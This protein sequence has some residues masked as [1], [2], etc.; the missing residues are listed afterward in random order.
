MWS[1]ILHDV[2]LSTEGGLTFIAT[3]VLHVPVSALSLGAFVRKNDLQD[4][5][6]HNENQQNSAML[7]D[8]EKRLK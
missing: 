3:E 4:Q 7:S 2:A 6:G 5:N 1:S 8:G